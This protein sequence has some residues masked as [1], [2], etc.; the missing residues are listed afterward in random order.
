M[1]LKSR[2]KTYLDRSH[3]KNSPHTYK[4]MFNLTNNKKKI[5]EINPI[6]TDWTGKTLKV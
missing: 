3:T 5:T 6:F 4:K 2:E 1:Y